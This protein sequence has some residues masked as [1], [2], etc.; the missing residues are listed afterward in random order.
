MQYSSQLIVEQILVE[1]L[2]KQQLQDLPKHMYRLQ[3]QL[4]EA[5]KEA[6]QKQA[7]VILDLLLE[8]QP[9]I[10][11]LGLEVRAKTNSSL[12][13]PFTKREVNSKRS[14]PRSQNLRRNPRSLRSNR[15]NSTG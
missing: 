6:L 2:T 10:I 3:G 13:Q 15:R 8:G 1:A 7:I 11:S 9:Q 5:L 12:Y 4:R 14:A